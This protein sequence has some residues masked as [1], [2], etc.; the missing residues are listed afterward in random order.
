MV[1]PTGNLECAKIA[2]VLPVHPT[3][4]VNI[5]DVI[6]EGSRMTLPRRWDEPDTL[7]FGP[8]PGDG[9]KGPSIV[10]VVLRIKFRQI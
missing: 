9:I 8:G 4:T 3:A 5:N 7:K 6:N 10:V 2:Q 1:T